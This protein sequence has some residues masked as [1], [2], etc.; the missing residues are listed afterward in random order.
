[1]MSKSKISHNMVFGDYLST[2]MQSILQELFIPLEI[3]LFTNSKTNFENL[4]GSFKK[5]GHYRFLIPIN[6]TNNS[7]R[8]LS[9]ALVNK[10]SKLSSV[11]T[12]SRIIN[13]FSAQSRIK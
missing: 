1:M 6:W 8:A 4:K 5:L 3:S 12:F 7:K 2:A 9:K 13:F 11:N 10:S